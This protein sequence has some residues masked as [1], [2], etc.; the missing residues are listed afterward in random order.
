MNPFSA[1][2]NRPFSIFR[3]IFLCPWPTFLSSC[4]HNPVVPP[5]REWV[6]NGNFWE[7]SNLGEQE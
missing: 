6:T 3:L 5:D 1:L 2:L 7:K 4:E